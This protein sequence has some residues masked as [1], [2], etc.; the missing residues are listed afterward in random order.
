MT[1]HHQPNATTT[2]RQIASRSYATLATVSPAGRP[3]VA[4]VLYE[5]VDDSAARTAPSL[6]V[7][8]LRTSRKARN[9]DDDPLRVL[10]PGLCIVFIVLC[11]NFLGDGLRDAL[12][13]RSKAEGNKPVKAAKDKN[14]AG[15]DAGEAVGSV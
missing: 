7:N 11:V 10:T 9:I 3:H 4:G 2:L 13:P 15:V 5:L 12:D 8:T 1:Q 14:A 6:F